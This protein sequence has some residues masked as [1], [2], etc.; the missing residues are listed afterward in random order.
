MFLFF[1]LRNSEKSEEENE[2]RNPTTC[3][4]SVTKLGDCHAVTFLCTH[5]SRKMDRFGGRN[6]INRS[7]PH[8]IFHKDDSII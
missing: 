8:T 1:L 4:A 7:P 2:T 6:N 5:T 3:Q